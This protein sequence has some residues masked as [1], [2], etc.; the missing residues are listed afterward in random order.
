[1]TIWVSSQPI[2]AKLQCLTRDKTTRYTR[3]S[4]QAL[5]KKK[6]KSHSILP[7][8][9][10]LKP[11]AQCTNLKAETWQTKPQRTPKLPQFNSSTLSLAPPASTLFHTFHTFLVSHKTVKAYAS[12]IF[13]CSASLVL[14][15]LSSLSLATY[16]PHSLD[17]AT[18]SPI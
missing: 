2:R 7:I 1:M 14:S 5:K 3:L 16:R 12:T 15:V 9:H 11:K 17:L 10:C 4:R 6:K 18:C 13:H 8:V